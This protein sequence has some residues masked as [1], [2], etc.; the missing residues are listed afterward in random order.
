MILNP[1]AIVIDV[2]ATLGG[3]QPGATSYADHKAYINANGQAAYLTA[4]EGMFATQTNATMSATILGNLGLA[5]V[6]TAA[7]GEAYLAANAGNRVKAALDLASALT[8]Y[9]SDATNT[10]DTAILAA[11]ATYV[12]TAAN[13][14]A[15]A[16]NSANTSDAATS[17]AAIVNT[18]QTFTLTTGSNNFTGTSSA[19]TFDAGLSTGSLQTFNSGDR[20]DGGDGTDELLAVV[21]GSVTPASMLNIEN[22]TA[23]VTT[24]ASTIDLA[25]ATGLTAVSLTGATAAATLSNIATSVAVTL[26]DSAVAHTVTYSDVAGA[27]NAAT[28][29]VMNMS[30]GTG[31]VTTIAGIE[32]LT[33]N[34]TSSDS[35]L[36]TLTAAATTTL[37]VT[38]DKELT[39]VDN[40]GST[41]LTVD[42]STSTGGMDLDFGGTNI[43][44]TGGSGNDAL[45]FEA[46]GDVVVDGGAG[47]DTFT[48]DATGTFTTADTV[49]GGDGTDTLS[50]TSANLV[51][52]SS[53]TPTTYT[54][55]GIE[56][57]TA[58]TAVANGAAITLGNISET[59][60]RLTLTAANAGTSTFN[61][62]AGDSTLSNAVASVGNIAIDAAG[63]AT[64]D[65]LT[66]VHGAA[67]A[68]DS[69]NGVDLTSTDFE[70]VTINTTGTGAAGAQTAGAIS[71]TASTDGTPTLNITGSN[72]L[73]VGVITA[74]G[75]AVN[76]SGMTASANGLIM[77]TGQNTAST[78]TGSS[79]VDTLFGAITTAI[80]QTIDGGA[81][82]D[83]ITAGAGNDSILGGD[84]DDAINGAAGNDFID[85]GA[86]SD[87]V[88][89]A[90]DGN[91]SSADTL[92]G[93][94]GTDTLSFEAAMTNSASQFSGVSGFEVLDIDAGA[95]DTITLT[96]FINNSTFTRIDF[97]D[98]GGAAALVADGVGSGVTDI[99]LLAGQAADS[100]T[101]T[102]LV[103]STTNEITVS[104]RAAIATGV[105]LSLA[106]EET[107]NISGSAAT[108]DVNYDDFTA[109]D[110]VT[111]NISGAADI[112]FDGVV[113]GSRVA[114]VN[115]SAATGAI[116]VHLTNN[117]VSATMTGGSAAN[118]F[119]GGL[120]AD[121]ITTFGGADVVIGGAGADII[122]LGAGNDTVTGG[123]GADVI[124]VGS[125]TDT[126][127]MVGGSSAD[128]TATAQTITALSVTGADVYT[129]LA[130]GD[131]IRFADSGGLDAFT[132]VG[133][134][135]DGVF[136]TAALVTTTTVA[137]SANLIRGSWVEGTT[138]GSGTFIA[139]SAGADTLYVADVDGTNATNDFEAIVLVGTA[140][141]TGN[142]AFVAGGTI[143]LTLA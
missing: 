1:Y 107:I 133:V 22:L 126:V 62:N 129:G 132:A 98:A 110:L 42:G 108:S 105:T 7:Q 90:A 143:E 21:N 45:S 29:D 10:N 13:A 121:T 26:R 41:I 72:E 14:Y 25:N 78:I 116:E 70:T 69:L 87:T 12:A 128:L 19:D 95:A 103:D 5:S 32:T 134:A 24:N 6:F 131:T 112:G 71:L 127:V 111:L 77:V 120:L 88:T 140:G 17:S 142:H 114:T 115:A 58:N 85:G 86:G 76:A 81:G 3:K 73:T 74:T 119:T 2:Y 66:I 18:G 51:T 35:A 28:V 99:R 64:T 97:D 93:G 100:A 44:V 33:I 15:Y 54:V 37:N 106:D 47:N 65:S 102:R 136:V 124:N 46:A 9:V 61:F 36:G 125:G 91:L 139:D 89:I 75:G 20:L 122:S 138:T 4:L 43:T 68:V 94:D 55:T 40:L 63:T 39:V 59:A 16:S 104:V 53:A 96:N 84:G 8:N 83:A 38:G 109:T 30:Q 130:A 49:T 52:A 80:S 31:V 50:A 23:T 56:R 118:E 34:A 137:N 117:V 48:F 113:S 141:V 60:N 135:G 67:S 123:T 82:N 101:L 57:L 27:A 79:A 11:K 92:I